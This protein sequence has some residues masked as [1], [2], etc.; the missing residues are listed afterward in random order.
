MMNDSIAQTIQRYVED[1]LLDEDL[2]I[3]RS[4]RLFE[5]GLIDSMNLVK[6]LSFIEETFDIKIPVS[7]VT[8]DNFASVD[9]MAGLVCQVKV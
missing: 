4:D 8:D 6:L 3:G 9:A 1:E 5:Q 7:M 2:S